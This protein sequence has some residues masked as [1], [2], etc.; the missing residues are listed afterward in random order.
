MYFIE[1]PAFP[2]ANDAN[3]TVIWIKI[4]ENGIF[5]C[6]ACKT[7]CTQLPIDYVLVWKYEMLKSNFTWPTSSRYPLTITAW[8]TR[9]VNLS[10]TE[11]LRNC[12]L[13]SPLQNLV[14]HDKA[15]LSKQLKKWRLHSFDIHCWLSMITYHQTKSLAFTNIPASM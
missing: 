10:T 15:A 6:L 11:P 2:E 14:R 3:M 1:L 5:F 4:S 9:L 12:L 7:S 8:G 13:T